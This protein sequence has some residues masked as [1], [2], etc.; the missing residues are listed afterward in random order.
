MALCDIDE[1]LLK[2]KKEE[3][4]DINSRHLVWIFNRLLTVLGFVHGLGVTHGAVLPEH[5]LIRKRDH[6]LMLIDW[7]YAVKGTDFFIYPNIQ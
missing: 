4:P 2:E 7:S 1:N 6:A 3:Y 5:I